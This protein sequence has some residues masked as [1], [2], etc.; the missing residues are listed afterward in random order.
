IAALYY[1]RPLWLT[2]DFGENWKETDSGCEQWAAMDIS[3][4]GKY[5]VLADF[6]AIKYY[7]ENKS[8]I[9]ISKDSGKTWECKEID[10]IQCLYDVAISNDGK[11]IIVGS[12]RVM[13]PFM[14]SFNS[15]ESWEAISKPD[16]VNQDWPSFNSVFS[17]SGTRIVAMEKGYSIWTSDDYGVTWVER[18]RGEGG[19]I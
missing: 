8:A 13:D 9:H 2:N 3:S 15:G 17:A 1:Y 7:P 4:D 16:F 18:I 19:Q 12:N 10:G 6:G 11:K 5:I 14:I